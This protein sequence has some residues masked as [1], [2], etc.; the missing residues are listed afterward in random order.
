MSYAVIVKAAFLAEAK[1][2]AVKKKAQ[3]GSG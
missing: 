1:S 3:V 2:Y